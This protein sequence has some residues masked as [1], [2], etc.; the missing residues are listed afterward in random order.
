[1]SDLFGQLKLKLKI[2]WEDDSTDERLK[3]IVSSAKLIM[4][5]KLGLA[6]G[7][8][9]TDSGMEQNLFLNYCMYEWNN[10]ANQFDSNY[11]NEIMQVRAKWEVETYREG[12]ANADE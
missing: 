3:Q 7:F 8:A 6:E 12:Q 5:H 11:R 2:T 10:S 4:I 1:M 9:F